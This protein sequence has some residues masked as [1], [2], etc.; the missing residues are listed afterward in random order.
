MARRRRRRGGTEA[1]QCVANAAMP[2]PTVPPLPFFLFSL[3]SPEIPF[4]LLPPCFPPAPPCSPQLPPSFCP[5]RLTPALLPTAPELLPLLH[6]H[7]SCF[8]CET[9]CETPARPLPFFLISLSSPETLARP[10]FFLPHPC[11]ASSPALPLR[12]PA[13]LLAFVHLCSYFPP[14]WLLEHQTILYGGGQHR[15]GRL[16]Q[17]PR[18][19]PPTRCFHFPLA[20]APPLSCL[21]PISTPFHPF[22]PVPL[23]RSSAAHPPALPPP[24]LL[25]STL[26]VA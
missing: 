17:P 11:P 23:P 22:L 3:S 16:L 7:P 25:L 13:P 2:E 26:L 4:F 10:R 9:S 8:P 1:R 21:T 19:S 18:H 5:L 24:L 14:F 15:L 6:L 12:D 20:I